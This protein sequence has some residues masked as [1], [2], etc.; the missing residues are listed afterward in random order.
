MAA[1]GIDFFFD[2]AFGLKVSAS[3][4]PQS[5][6][7]ERFY[8]GYDRAFILPDEREELDGFRK[9]LAMNETHSDAFGRTHRELVVVL[10]DDSGTMLGGANFLVTAMP[11][12]AGW[13]RATVALNYIFVEREA[14]GRGLLRQLL[15]AVRRMSQLVVDLPTEVARPTIF[16]EQNDPLRLTENEFLLDTRYSGTDQIDRLAIWDRLEAR[17][18]DFPYVQPPLSPGQQPDDRLIYAAIDHPD[19]TIDAGLLHDHLESFF[20]ISVLKGAAEPP[21]GVAAT[22]LGV[23]AARVEPV[24]LLRIGAAL[25]ALRASRCAGTVRSAPASLRD[26]IRL[27][28]V[29]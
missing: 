13:P 7:L 4:D 27:T 16:I 21:G 24:P 22:Q 8:A 17:I 18:V 26:L 23:L 25:P 9:C 6:I 29:A 12:R 11:R 28:G 10:D 5:A 15:T 2:L 1:D 19:P 14:R 3:G 20:A